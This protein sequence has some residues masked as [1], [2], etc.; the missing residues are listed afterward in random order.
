METIRKAEE[1]TMY[2]WYTEEMLDEYAED[3]ISSLE[4]SC[5]YVQAHG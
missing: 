1:F 3:I 5:K 2:D 4:E